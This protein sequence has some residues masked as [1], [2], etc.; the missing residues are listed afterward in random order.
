MGFNFTGFLQGIDGASKIMNMYHGIRDRE[1]R[2]IQWEREQAYRKERDKRHDFESDRNFELQK[3]NN[4]RN[5]EIQKGYL[6]INQS[7]LGLQY[8]KYYDDRADKNAQNQAWY[9][10]QQATIGADGTESGFSNGEIE[11]AIPNAVA[12]NG[13]GN[14]I[15]A[16][17]GVK[18]PAGAPTNGGF[19]AIQNLKNN[20]LTIGYAFKSQDANGKI[21]NHLTSV[22]DDIPESEVYSALSSNPAT[23][24]LPFTQVLAARNEASLQADKV[25]QSSQQRLADTQPKGDNVDTQMNRY[26]NQ[27][28]NIGKNGDDKT[29]A[30]VQQEIQNVVASRGTELWGQRGKTL[31]DGLSVLNTRSKTVNEA[32]NKVIAQRTADEYQDDFIKAETETLDSEGKLRRVPTN[33]ATNKDLEAFASSISSSGSKKSSSDKNKGS[34]N[35]TSAMAYAITADMQDRYGGKVPLSALNNPATKAKAMQVRSVMEK[36]GLSSPI[37]A[38]A[39]IRGQQIFGGDTENINNV[40][41]AAERALIQLEAAG[42][43]P[44]QATNAVKGAIIQL[45]KDKRISSFEKNILKNA[46]VVAPEQEKQEQQQQLRKSLGTINYPVWAGLYGE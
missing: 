41:A 19:G 36:Y 25:K 31:A 13:E 37:A 21:T 34:Y 11:S 39:S 43:S 20:N 16:A 14:A 35:N 42:V 28:I 22:I 24:N 15:A 33:Y 4:D 38:I 9:D 10:L 6:G 44:E 18:V 5:Y 2:R 27:L 29:K 1:D 30:A 3:I 45:S 46:G 17:L 40:N 23:A 32:V 8:R 26:L 7:N 12:F